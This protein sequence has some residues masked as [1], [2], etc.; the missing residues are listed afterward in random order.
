M[1]LEETFTYAFGAKSC[2]LKLLCYSINEEYDLIAD[3]NI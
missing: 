3:K 1:I 2:I